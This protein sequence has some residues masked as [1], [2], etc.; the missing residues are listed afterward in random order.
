MSKAMFLSL[1]SLELRWGKEKKKQ[2]TG[3]GRTVSLA[4]EIIGYLS[5]KSVR[6]SQTFKCRHTY[7][8]TH[9]YMIYLIY[10]DI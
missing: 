10:V 2:K 8:H 1:R 6:N 7:T 4:E 5:H 3:I 9:K